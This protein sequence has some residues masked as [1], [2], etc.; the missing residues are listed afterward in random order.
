MSVTI[1]KCTASAIAKA[2]AAT[3]PLVIMRV[4]GTTPL[5]APAT[6]REERVQD[7][8][9]NKDNAPNYE[10]QDYS[11]FESTLEKV[12]EMAQLGKEQQSTFHW[13]QAVRSAYRRRGIEGPISYI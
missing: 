13:E 7:Y 4:Y 10:Y 6:T 8:R 1:A 12:L 3:K 11:S 5:A 9:F 2:R